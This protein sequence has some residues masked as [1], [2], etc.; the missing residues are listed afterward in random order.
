[1]ANASRHDCSPSVGEYGKST[2]PYFKFQ[3]QL[4]HIL[5]EVEVESGEI[6]RVP[7]PEYI[8]TVLIAKSAGAAGGVSFAAAK[9]GCMSCLRRYEGW[10][11]ATSCTEE[12][13]RV[14][15]LIRAVD[16]L[17][18]EYADRLPIGTSTL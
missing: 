12:L 16:V 3:V 9:A 6:Q 5:H 17:D 10:L 8:D 11:D 14:R 13:E 2:V 1:M 7:G 4:A 18:D 15:A